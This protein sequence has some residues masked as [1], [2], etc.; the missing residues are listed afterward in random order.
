MGKN[1]RKVSAHLNRPDSGSD[2][3]AIDNYQV[4]V[5]SLVLRE[6][7]QQLVRELALW[8]VSSGNQMAL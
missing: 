3:R 7:A 6:N 1:L 2:D 5:M 4:R 8:K